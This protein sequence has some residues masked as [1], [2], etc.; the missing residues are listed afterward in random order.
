MKAGWSSAKSYIYNEFKSLQMP[1][2]Y[3]TPSMAIKSQ[4]LF[5][6]ESTVN[7]SAKLTL[8]REQVVKFLSN[9]LDWILNKSAVLCNRLFA[10]A[11]C[12]F[13]L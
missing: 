10:P 7:L 3:S 2:D 8:N 13:S 1:F 5:A 11:T 6:C 4:V 12:F 9:K